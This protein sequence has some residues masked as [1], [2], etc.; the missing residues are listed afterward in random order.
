MASVTD[1]YMGLSRNDFIVYTC[2]E[3]I[4]KVTPGAL[5]KEAGRTRRER[6]RASGADCVLS[7]NRLI[8]ISIR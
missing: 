8:Q 6:R 7:R 4:T 1:A 2:G 3:Q 5:Q